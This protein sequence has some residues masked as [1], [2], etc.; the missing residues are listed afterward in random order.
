[1]R[2]A[3]GW[4]CVSIAVGIALALPFARA[5]DIPVPEQSED[6]PW[7]VRCVVESLHVDGLPIVQHS[8]CAWDTSRRAWVPM[9]RD[10]AQQRV[11]GIR[12]LED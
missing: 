7:I 4:H 2:S 1:M 6:M 12:P 8:W 9:S 3:C 10:L 11:F 5:A